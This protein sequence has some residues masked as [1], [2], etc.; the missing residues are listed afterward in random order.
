MKDQRAKNTQINTPRNARRTKR[1]TLG[2][3]TRGNK[4]QTIPEAP[5]EPKALTLAD[6]HGEN[7]PQIKKRDKEDT[8]PNQ[9][10]NGREEEGEDKSRA[11]SGPHQRT[12]RLTPRLIDY[13]CARPVRS[14]TSKQKLRMPQPRKGPFPR[15]A[16]QHQG[17]NATTRQLCLHPRGTQDRWQAHLQIACSTKALLSS[18]EG[19]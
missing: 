14:R 15:V 17:F 16:T 13:N 2:R 1:L 4:P 8:R 5:G 3:L 12:Q 6:W 9:E 18:R 7:K 11:E 10:L 19:D